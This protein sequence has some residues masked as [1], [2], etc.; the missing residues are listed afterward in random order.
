MCPNLSSSYLLMSSTAGTTF[1]SILVAWLASSLAFAPATLDVPKAGRSAGH[2]LFQISP[3]P[4][5]ADWT[6]DNGKALRDLLKACSTRDD[7]ASK[8]LAEVLATH[9][10]LRDLVPH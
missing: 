8:R 2:H 9:P 6:A 10:A 3:I 7:P 4:P 1:A 5:G